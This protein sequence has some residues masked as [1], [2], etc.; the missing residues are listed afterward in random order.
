MCLVSNQPALFFATAKTQ[1][2]KAIENMNVDQLKLCSVIDQA[3]TYIYN[4][5]KVIDKY[6]RLLVKNK[7]AISNTLT[8][9]DLIKNLTNSDEY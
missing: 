2:F 5:S 3:S 1:K 7:F 8:F 6:H 9:P 4:T